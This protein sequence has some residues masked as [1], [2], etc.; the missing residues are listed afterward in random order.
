MDFLSVAT[1]DG[2]ANACW[3]WSMGTARSSDTC[4]IGMAATFFEPVRYSVFGQH[5][6]RQM[7]L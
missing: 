1:V 5:R 2:K 6:I 7:A 4:G 3:D